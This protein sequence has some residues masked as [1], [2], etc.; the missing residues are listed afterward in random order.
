ME[1]EL[2]A[3][4]TLMPKFNH[5]DSKFC[6]RAKLNYEE[7]SDILKLE[8]A[9]KNLAVK[10]KGLCSTSVGFQGQDCNN[11]KFLVLENFL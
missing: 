7:N 1:C 3:L 6:Q 8:L 2:I 5:I 11:V 4:L 9:V 10:T